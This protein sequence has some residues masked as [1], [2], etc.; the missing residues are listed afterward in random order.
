VLELSF[1]LGNAH[2]KKQ[3]IA[4]QLHTHVLTSGGLDQQDIMGKFMVCP[5]DTLN[6]PFRFQSMDQHAC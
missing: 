4:A 1:Q 3:S 6:G 2:G 5:G